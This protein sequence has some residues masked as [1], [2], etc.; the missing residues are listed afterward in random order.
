M[1]FNLWTVLFSCLAFQSLITGNV[2]IWH[3]GRKEK[4]TR[5]IGIILLMFGLTL[6]EYVLFWTHYQKIFPYFIAISVAFPLCF[7]PLF[8]LYFRQLLTPQPIDKKYLWHFLPA[9]IRFAYQI[10]LYVAPAAKKFELLKM[11]NFKGEHLF[12]QNIMPWIETGQMLI[13]GVLILVFLRQHNMLTEM[14]KWANYV[15]FFYVGYILSISSYYVLVHFSFFNP[16]WDYGISFMMAAFI[17][18]VAIFAYIQIPIFEGYR[19]Q[20]MPT[21]LISPKYEHTKLSPLL[22]QELTK[23]LTSLMEGEKLYIENDLGLE[24][25]AQRVG[26][27]RHILSQFL[28]EHLGLSF[29]E[30]INSLRIAA[31]KELLTT[32]AKQEL[33]VIEIAYQVGF[34]N[35][36][37]FNQA[38]KKITGRT[39]T[40]F[41]AERELNP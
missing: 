16:A 12:F 20:E 24:K 29:F 11:E 27:N 38:F 34:N 35:K 22:I 10:P 5:F 21:V 4:S 23:K 9:I 19:L 30:Y 3:F 13:Y 15:L 40:E 33:N 17:A 39:P 26:T 18:F 36:V 37:S 32:T 6:V 8:Y 2:F 31:A 28:N 7:G 14:R 1:G 41:R 25:L